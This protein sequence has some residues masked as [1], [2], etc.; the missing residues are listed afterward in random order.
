MATFNN[1][2]ASVGLSDPKL[3]RQTETALAQASIIAQGKPTVTSAGEIILPSTTLAVGVNAV[4]TTTSANNSSADIVT[5]YS[6]QGTI[7]ASSIDQTV[8]QTVVNQIGVSSIVAG[9]N[10]TIT[11]TGSSQGTGIVTINATGGNGG[12]GTPGGSNT[13]VQFND[14]G[15][16]GGNLG[17]TFNKITSLLSAPYFGGNGSN[18]T[19]IPGANVTGT[20][21]FAG[22]A[23]AVALAN[24][25]GAGNI[26]SINL[27]GSNSNVLYGN[28]TFGAVPVTAFTANVN[29]GGF[30]LGN[31]GNIAV[32]GAITVTGNITAANFIGSGA[33]TPTISSAT[34]LD[35][36][37]ASAVRVV[38]G[39]IF[40]LPS[41][42]TG[43]I[44]NTIAAN[45][46]MIYNSST[47][48]FQGYENGAWAN[49]I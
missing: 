47:N 37:A 16:F 6:S 46:D 45:G 41:L 11:S 49:L 15:S 25:S 40:R 42:T 43:Q 1:K 48:K 8:N 32:T 39:G 28:G 14:A 7:Y 19:G 10:V 3:V 12:N 34:N 27:T 33:N 44:A 21:P 2:P 24:V 17:F 26:A 36:S 22:T 18:L 4:S 29:G 38:G 31:V 30:S 5:V 13:F 23:N 20:V 9:N 35:L